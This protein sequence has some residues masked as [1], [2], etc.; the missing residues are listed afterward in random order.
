[1]LSEGDRFGA[2]PEGTHGQVL[3]EFVSANPTGLLHVGYGRQAALGDALA[4]LLSWQGWSVHREFYYND[5]GVQRSTRWR[6]RCRRG[7]RGLRPG[8]AAKPARPAGQRRL[9][10]RY[11]QAD[12]LAG[13][14]RERFDGEPASW[15]RRAIS[16]TFE[17]IRQALRSA[18][19]ARQQSRISTCSVLGSARMVL[20]SSRRCTA[21]AVEA[22]VQSLEARGQYLRERGRALATHRRRQATTRIAS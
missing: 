21:T 6:S 2:R 19:P 7:A 22:A 9:H 3:V 13:G 12:F 4:N 18:W 15:R 20:A 14:D 5:A 10:R 11:R 16:K 8:D 1:M 17:S